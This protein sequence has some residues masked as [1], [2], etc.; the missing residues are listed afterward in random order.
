MVLHHESHK[1]ASARPKRNI[2]PRSRDSVHVLKRLFSL[3][4]LRTL[5]ALLT[6]VLNT[7]PLILT[8]AQLAIVAILSGGSLA[9]ACAFNV[10]YLCSLLHQLQIAVQKTYV[11][12]LYSFWFISRI[13]IY[14][15]GVSAIL[16]SGVI[17]Q[18]KNTFFLWRHVVK[19]TWPVPM[20]FSRMIERG[21]FRDCHPL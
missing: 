15:I 12:F 11:L 14:C 1:K 5:L 17:K 9:L 6:L 18:Q 2:R 10:S 7:P 4:S 8:C 13:S 3:L 21:L 19:N 20:I 16:Q